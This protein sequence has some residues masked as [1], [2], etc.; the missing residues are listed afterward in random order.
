MKSG[1]EVSILL[2]TLNRAHYL[3]ELLPHLDRQAVDLG[4]PVEIVVVDNG[5]SDDT[6]QVVR[7]FSSRA[8]SP[9]HYVF[10]PR[11]GISLVRNR[12]MSEASGKWF[13]FI[14]DDEIPD[15]QW[16]SELFRAAESTG[17][18]ILGGS[19]RL[20]MS[21][22]DLFHLG[23]ESRQAL[24]EHET[25]L[26]D[27]GLSPSGKKNYPG[28]GNM[29][30]HR[31]VVESVGSFDES[32]TM[33]GGDHDL[34]RRAHEAGFE[35]WF[36]PS[37]VVVHRIPEG[38]LNEEAFITDSLQSGAMLAYLRHRYDGVIL[39]VGE[40]AARCAHSL[41][42]TAPLIAKARVFGSDAEVLDRKIKWWR[43]VGYLR[44]A[45]SLIAPKFPGAKDFSARVDF[46]TSRTNEGNRGSAEGDRGSDGVD[47][48]GPSMQSG[49]DL[50]KDD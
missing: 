14:D 23:D 19:L 50:Q 43:M 36:V 11:S 7:D 4:V 31:E 5:S 6:N 1:C 26:L 45:A 2:C 13:A 41:V 32:M 47:S 9:V 37:A 20:D 30:M 8:Q 40:A 46:R 42:V 3:A 27:R 39:L 35:P 38:R 34:M 22:E 12:S 24:R 48:G 49:G 15:E 25:E 17:A 33:G 44:Y 16:L 28:P 10:E 29:L 18:K 21:E